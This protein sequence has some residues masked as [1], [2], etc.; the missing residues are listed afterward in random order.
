M[1]YKK[2][3]FKCYSNILLH[4]NFYIGGYRHSPRSPTFHIA[5]TLWLMQ[6][7]INKMIKNFGFLASIIMLTGCIQKTNPANFIISDKNEITHIYIDEN[8]DSLITW[9]I[10]DFADDI[11]DVT[12][13]KIIIEKCKTIR[14]GKGIY[15][16][17]FKDP[18]IKSIDNEQIKKLNGAWEKYYIKT[19]KNSLIIA[20]S[21]IRGTVYGIFEVAE[22][23]FNFCCV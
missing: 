13:N 5:E 6:K 17:E 8:V 20:G 15:I 21:D 10:N 7:P 2:L 19:Y 3:G 16:G 23:Y 11:E 12:G 18:L 14:K 1:V 4:C 22:R 9:A